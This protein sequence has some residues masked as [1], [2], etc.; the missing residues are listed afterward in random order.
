MYKLILTQSPLKNLSARARRSNLNLET[1]SLS[2]NI[3]MIS[4][5]RYGQFRL[6]ACSMFYYTSSSSSRS[7]FIYASMVVKVWST[8]SYSSD[9]AAAI[10]WVKSSGA[11]G[12]FRAPFASSRQLKRNIRSSSSSS[13]GARAFLHHMMSWIIMIA[14]SSFELVV[15]SPHL[16]N[17]STLEPVHLL[18]AKIFSSDFLQLHT[19]F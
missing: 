13:G 5:I 14:A 3:Q 19:T 17:I 9:G 12:E 7:R 2:Y 1:C 8:F 4:L 18:T 16:K 10:A 11:C 6:G 15:V